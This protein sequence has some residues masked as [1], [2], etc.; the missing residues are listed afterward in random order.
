MESNKDDGSDNFV[1]NL[2]LN[3]KIIGIPYEG[4]KD[5]TLKTF[6]SILI[7]FLEAESNKG[8][9]SNDTIRDATQADIDAYYSSGK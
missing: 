1:P 5:I 4:L 9:K 3:A 2:I 8:A 7:S 6:D